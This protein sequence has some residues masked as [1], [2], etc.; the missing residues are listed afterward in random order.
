M[1][2]DHHTLKALVD[3]VDEK[4]R[5]AEHKWGKG[6]LPLLVDADTRAKFYAAAEKFNDALVACYG[7]KVITRDMID[8]VKAKGAVMERAWVALDGKA[9]EAGHKALDPD[10]WEVVLKDGSIAAI[11][12][13]NADAGKVLAD[14]RNKNVWTLEEVGRAIDAFPEVVNGIKEAFPGVTVEPVREKRTRFVPDTHIPF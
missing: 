8:H 4:A 9:T 6:R 12:Q 2:D 10:V 3:G 5:L 14:G 13:T 7:A 11:V 1:S